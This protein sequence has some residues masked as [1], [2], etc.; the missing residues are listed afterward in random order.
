MQQRIYIYINTYYV[1]GRLG[2]IIGMLLL[3]HSRLVW[4]LLGYVTRFMICHVWS[5]PEQD[6]EYINVA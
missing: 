1:G 4:D 6:R 2:V 5:F 3:G